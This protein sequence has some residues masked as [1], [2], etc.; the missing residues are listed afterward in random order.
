MVFIFSLFAF[1]YMFFCVYL[2]SLNKV[3]KVFFILFVCGLSSVFSAYLSHDSA[4]YHH[5]YANYSGAAFNSVFNEMLG[6][7]LFFLILSKVSNPFHI[8]FFFFVYAILSFSIK[9]ALIERV[10]RMPVLSLSL[11]F[12]FFFLYLDGTVIRV[13]LGIAIAYW[14]I[15]LLSKNNFIGFL[16]VILLSTLLF[17]Y[18]LIVLLIMPFFRSHLSILFTILMMFLFLALF[19][20]GYGVLDLLV[21]MTKNL[22]DSFVGLNKLISYLTYSQ[23][24]H[25]YSIFFIALF[26]S[27]VLAYLLFKNELNSFELIIFNMLFLSF[28]FLVVL[29]QSQV[30]Q[31]RISEIFRYSLVFVAPFFYYSLKNILKNS[32]RAMLSFNF[33]LSCYFFYYYYFKGIISEKNLG[34]LHTYFF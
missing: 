9:L 33:F 16:A 30:L 24:S 19:F 3:N 7:E 23:L 5:I 4:A 32:N 13:S 20:L 2:Y 26:S 31:N 10:S 28:F 27:S 25:P 17:H 34:F 1:F 22:D 8:F 18:S 6:Y 14:G 29:Y 15:Y 21:A 11:F 12:A